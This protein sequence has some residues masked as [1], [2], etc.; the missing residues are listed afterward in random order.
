[1]TDTEEIQLK[2]S[3][4]LDQNRPV[5]LE[6]ERVILG[7]VL[8]E[9]HALSKIIDLLVPANFSDNNQKYW[10]TIKRMYNKQPID[11]KTF[12]HEYVKA[13]PRDDIKATIDALINA[14]SCVNSSANIMTH[15]YMLL[16][17]GIV[18]RFLSLYT[19]HVHNKKVAAFAEDVL[20]ILLASS[21]KLKELDDMVDWLVSVLPD[22]EF[23]KDLVLQQ[24]SISRY[25]ANIKRQEA[26]R[27]NIN[28]LLALNNQKPSSATEALTAILIHTVSNPCTSEAFV[29]QVYH[30]KSMLHQ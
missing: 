17:H 24:K 20:E 21:D 28:N 1:M 25:T 5:R 14:V 7:A 16:E 19:T 11:F 15:A 10:S 4:W 18:A 26:I 22:E 9:P 27:V 2:V 8:I 29:N 23:T 6:L 30:L 3:R 12:T 13:Y